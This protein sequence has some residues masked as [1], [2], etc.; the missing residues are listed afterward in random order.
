MYTVIREVPDMWV[1]RYED[2]DDDIEALREKLKDYYG[3]AMMSGFPMA[4]LDLADVDDLSDEEVIE[5][6]RKNRIK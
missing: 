1:N 3:T 4:V 5:Q 2:D 6:V